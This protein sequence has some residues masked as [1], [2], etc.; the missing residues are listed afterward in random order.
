[1][2]ADWIDVLEHLIGGCTETCRLSPSG[3]AFFGHYERWR[4]PL[5]L[6]K[7]MREEV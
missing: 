2:G 5:L 3:S 1:M 6:F 4:R 7:M